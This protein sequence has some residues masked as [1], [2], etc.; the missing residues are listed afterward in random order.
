MTYDSLD[1]TFRTFKVRR[2]P[3]F[4]A[5]SEHAGVIQIAESDDLCMPHLVNA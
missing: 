4:R 2:D 5:C 3:E 1:Q